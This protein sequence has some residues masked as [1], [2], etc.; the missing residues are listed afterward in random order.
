M[1]TILGTATGGG[2][3]DTTRLT[4]RPDEKSPA[5]GVWSMTVPFGSGAARVEPTDAVRPWARAAATACWA[6]KPRRPGTAYAFALL[7]CAS[8]A[9]AR[10]AVRMR[11]IETIQ[12]TKRRSP[13]VTR[14]RT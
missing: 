6:V 4:F 11:T 12:G 1:F 3:S 7:T 2:P 10:P 13:G 8:T 5:A 14:L 9:N